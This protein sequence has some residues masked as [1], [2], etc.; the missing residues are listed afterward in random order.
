LDFVLDAAV[1]KLAGRRRFFP[2]SLVRL[3]H[4]KETGHCHI[5]ITFKDTS[6]VPKISRTKAASFNRKYHALEAFLCLKIHS[7][8]NALVTGFFSREAADTLYNP[9]LKLEWIALKKLPISDPCVVEIRETI[10]VG[11]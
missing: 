7:A 1:L 9:M 3:F 4:G 8:I 10:F 2:H 6:Q 11:V 5:V